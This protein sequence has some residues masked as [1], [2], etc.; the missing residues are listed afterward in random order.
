MQAITASFFMLLVSLPG[1]SQVQ[2]SNT[3]Q[4]DIHPAQIWL[5]TNGNAINAPGGCVLF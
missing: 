3:M 5:D 4:K 2:K 1:H